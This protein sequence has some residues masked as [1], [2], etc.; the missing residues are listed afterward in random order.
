MRASIAF[1]PKIIWR[2]I[3]SLNFSVSI[4]SHEVISGML[5]PIALL[6]REILHRKPAGVNGAELFQRRRGFARPRP[7]FFPAAVDFWYAPRQLRLVIA[8]RGEIYGG[9]LL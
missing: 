6:E 2:E 7:R 3:L 4:F 1:S 5:S 8:P 9:V